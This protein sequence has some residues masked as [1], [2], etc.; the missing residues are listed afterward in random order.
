MRELAIGD[1]HG[2][3]TAFQTMLDRLDPQP[4]DTIILLGDY[5]DRGPDSCGVIETIFELREKCTVVA[6]AG[7]HEKMLLDSLLDPQMLEE[8]LGHGGYETLD[9]YERHGYP[10]RTSG[11]PKPHWRFFNKEMRPS[12]E[13]AGHIYVHA[14]LD[15]ALDLDEQPEYLLLWEQFSDPTIHKSGKPI[16]CGHTRQKSGLPARFERGICIDT[17]AH[18]GGWLT[19]LDPNKQT[20]LQTNEQGD[21]RTIDV[22]T[23]PKATA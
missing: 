6:L 10:R 15:P 9:S 23:I 14:T 5:I 8:W 20:L 19:C 4:S 3:A 11:I 1:I 2:C 7:N 22:T 17:N 16:V 21:H 13:T 18:G 12:H